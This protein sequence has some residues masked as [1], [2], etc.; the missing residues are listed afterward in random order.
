MPGLQRASD[1]RKPLA[2][3][4]VQRTSMPSPKLQPAPDLRKAPVRRVVQRRTGVIQPAFDE[5]G[6]PLRLKKIFDI[7]DQLTVPIVAEYPSTTTFTPIKPVSALFSLLQTPIVTEF[8]PSMVTATEDEPPPLVDDEDAEVDRIRAIEDEETDWYFERERIKEELRAPAGAAWNALTAEKQA[9]DKG[10]S[11][12]ADIFSKLGMA[13]S[14]KKIE[15]FDK[16][17]ERWRVLHELMKEFQFSGEFQKLSAAHGRIQS[18]PIVELRAMV[19]DFVGPAERTQAELRETVKKMLALYKDI[20]PLL[21]KSGA[22]TGAR[23]QPDVAILASDS[24]TTAAGKFPRQISN[25]NAVASDMINRPTGGNTGFV[26]RLST[27]YHSS[28]GSSVGGNVGTVFWINQGP[29]RVIVAMGKHTGGN[30]NEYNITWYAH[31]ATASATP[32][33]LN[34][35]THKLQ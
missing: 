30:S 2:P 18:A 8:H 32:V 34:S 12:L 21:P 31:G 7:R 5:F 4:P 23:R 1:L 35:T 14:R 28:A 33:K 24:P 27:V 19:S 11:K 22:K 17:R 10:Y 25:G 29:R 3:A 6:T 26:V 15:G 13:N 16:L 9:A 20:E